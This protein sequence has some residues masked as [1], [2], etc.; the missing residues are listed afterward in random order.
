[1]TDARAEL[2]RLRR[3][4]DRLRERLPGER[5]GEKRDRNGEGSFKRRV[6]EA[7]AKSDDSVAV[8][9][10]REVVLADRNGG[11]HS[12]DQQSI[13]T[14]PMKELPSEQQLRNSATVLTH[15]PFQMR[16]MHR[17][18]SQFYEGQPM[19]MTNAALASALATDEATLE[20]E[21]APLVSKKTLRH[22]KTAEGEEAYELK[23]W[24]LFLLQL[25]LAA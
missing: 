16:A 9:V 13:W 19:Q 7:L 10:S 18:L 12:S 3:E 15:T 6:R 23:R 17:L 25:S 21:L 1:M 24:D 2:E 11:T 14:G 8:G 5:G 22:F 20:R 4:V